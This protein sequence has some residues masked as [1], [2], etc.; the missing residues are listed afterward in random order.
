MIID[1]IFAPKSGNRSV[2]TPAKSLLKAVSWRV[3]GTVDT[4]LISWWITGEWT[5]AMGIA[6]V[7]VVSKMILY[8]IHERIWAR[9]SIRKTKA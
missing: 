6:G 9:I 7:E 3:I 2:D 4:M 5:L 1:Y 8:F